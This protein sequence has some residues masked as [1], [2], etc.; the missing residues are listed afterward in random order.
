MPAGFCCQNDVKLCIIINFSAQKASNSCTL[1][2]IH[3]VLNVTNE[4]FFEYSLAFVVSL[5]QNTMHNH[6]I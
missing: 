4:C 3:P 5:L 1:T 2:Y 6:T